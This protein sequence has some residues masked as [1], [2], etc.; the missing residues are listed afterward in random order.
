MLFPFFRKIRQYNDSV[1]AGAHH[2][3]EVTMG[4][5]GPQSTKFEF[6]E[7]VFNNTSDA[8]TRKQ[9]SY[10]GIPGRGEV[11]LLSGE[12]DADD[13]NSVN[14]AFTLPNGRTPRN[15]ADVM[16]LYRMALDE[17]IFM[18]NAARQGH[19]PDSSGVFRIIRAFIAI[20]HYDRDMLLNLTTIKHSHDYIYHHSLNVCLLSIALSV[21]RGFP[22]KEIVQIAT[23]ALFHDVGM[24]MLPQ[25]IRFSRK[26]LDE[27]EWEMIKSHPSTGMMMISKLSQVSE[28]PGFICYQVHERENGSGYP[29]QCDSDTILDYARVVQVADVYDAKASG[30]SYHEADTPHTAMGFI[31]QMAEDM[32]LC[33]KTVNAFHACMS[34]YP[35]GSMVEL[36]NRSV[37]RVVHSNDH[38]PDSPIISI[39]TDPSGRWLTPAEISQVDLSTNPQI[40]IVGHYQQ[41]EAQTVDVMYGF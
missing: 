40:R 12:E 29:N 39:L 33:S 18:L 21:K 7:T 10:L 27:E 30:R 31:R 3:L 15:K 4:L 38:M 22:E 35:V 1:S 13:I 11:T 5:F 36:S 16:Q 32:L 23:G 19:Y 20:A 2:Q 24:M 25:E 17:T 6:K 34:S 8:A 37:A 9:T 26:A 28:L 41:P 14:R